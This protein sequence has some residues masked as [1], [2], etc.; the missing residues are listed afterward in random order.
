MQMLFSSNNNWHW[1]VLQW[2]SMQFFQWSPDSRI[3]WGEPPSVGRMTSNHAFYSRTEYLDKFL[4]K[5][6]FSFMCFWECV[7]L[8]L[9]SKAQ[10][11]GTLFKN[12]H[13]NDSWNWQL[14]LTSSSHS[15]EDPFTANE[16]V[17]KKA[18]QLQNRDHKYHGVKRL[19]A[20][21]AR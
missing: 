12:M 5:L 8:S 11:N 13:I 3:S 7:S 1:G 16:G 4:N 15:R 14:P 17:A 6:K 21:W 19:Q 9:L 10:L 18:K 2:P 20:A